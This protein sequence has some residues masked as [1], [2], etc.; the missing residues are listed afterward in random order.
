MLAGGVAR[1]P[2]HQYAW[3]IFCGAHTR[4]NHDLADAH[5]APRLLDFNARGP[6]VSAGWGLP[7]GAQVVHV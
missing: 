2:R 4:G 5:N 3:W 1:S 6:H 7:G